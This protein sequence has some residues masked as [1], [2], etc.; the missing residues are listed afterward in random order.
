MYT[1]LNQF[2]YAYHQFRPIIGYILV[3]LHDYK[4]FDDQT[5]GH[6]AISIFAISKEKVF[7]SLSLVCIETLTDGLPYQ[8]SCTYL[9]QTKEIYMEYDRLNETVYITLSFSTHHFQAISLQIQLF[10]QF[11]SSIQQ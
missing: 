1:K 2:L 4:T 8:N 7:S 5:R 6:R 11:I 10:L 9:V 3:F